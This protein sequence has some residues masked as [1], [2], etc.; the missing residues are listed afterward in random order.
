M[1]KA[2]T[3]SAW[4]K[5]LVGLTVSIWAVYLCVT[6]FDWT[7]VW[8]QI[9]SIPAGVVVL[10]VILYLAGFILRAWRASLMMA[11]MCQPSMKHSFAIVTIGYAVNNLLPLRMG[12]LAR[13]DAAARRYGIHRLAA[14]TQVAAER[15][16]DALSIVALLLV[17]LVFLNIDGPHS[18]VLVDL[19]TLASVFFVIGLIGFVLV[20]RCGEMIKI[21]LRK[22]GKLGD[23]LSMKVIDV[24]ACLGCSRRLGLVI[25]ASLLTWIFEA[26]SFSALAMYWEIRQ[27]ILTGLFVMGV[28]NLSVMLP[29]APGHIG[30]Y[31]WAVVL[32]LGALAV[33][34]NDAMGFAVVIHS[35]QWIT[36][37]LVGS[38]FIVLPLLSRMDEL[39]GHHSD[40]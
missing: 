11:K 3:K 32:A 19:V 28:V 37:T 33:K 2:V 10:A 15:I 9:A 7:E 5:A 34:G 25:V 36:I 30:V 16:L 31:H 17:S 21:L 24:L 13:A 12:E 18:D 4:L 35:L 26:S 6:R 1:G 40:G 22:F 38:V 39:R 20:I 23:L 8:Q 27:P 29:S 14:I